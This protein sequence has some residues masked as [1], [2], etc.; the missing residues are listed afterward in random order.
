MREK[1]IPMIVRRHM[2]DG[3][4]EDWKVSDLEIEGSLDVLGSCGPYLDKPA[5]KLN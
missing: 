4:Y 5:H 3:S 2:P 1:R